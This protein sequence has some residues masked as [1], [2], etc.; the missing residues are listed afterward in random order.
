[1]NL[2]LTRRSTGDPLPVGPHRPTADITTT[3]RTDETRS[4]RAS[5]LIKPVRDAASSAKT[6]A[7]P[8]HPATAKAHEVHTS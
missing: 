3:A 5:S 4:D 1:M 7:A 2:T 6:P 8:R